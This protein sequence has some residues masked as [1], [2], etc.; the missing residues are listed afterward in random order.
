MATD[1]VGDELLAQPLLAVDAVEGALE[2]L[3]L[4]ERGLA[5]HL[6][7]AVGGVLAHR[8]SFIR[9]IYEK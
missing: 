1:E 7:H 2:L 4:A 9:I 3:E 5:H 8:H 6:Q